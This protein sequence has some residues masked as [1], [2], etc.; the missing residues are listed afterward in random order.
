[1]LTVEAKLHQ[2]LGD[3]AY[4][5]FS[6]DNCLE[7]MAPGVSKGHALQLVLDEL[8]IATPIAWRLAM[9]RTISNCCRL[10]VIHG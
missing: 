6:A 9:A 5:T 2:A 8:A 4:I 1:L 10:P 7:V 3:H